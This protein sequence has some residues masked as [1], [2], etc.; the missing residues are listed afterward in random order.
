M[1]VKTANRSSL[2]SASSSY[3]FTTTPRSIVSNKPQRRKYREPSETGMKEPFNMMHD[4]RIRRGSTIVT[5]KQQQQ[6]QEEEE[7]QRKAEAL[8]KQRERLR[9]QQQL[10][11]RKPDTP[12]PIEGR[13][14][15]LFP[16]N[17]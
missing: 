7:A 14:H 3:T 4:P 2:Q 17:Q 6:A 9:L 16:C 1:S 11:Q 15:I 13:Q 12:E 10:E 8:R 5:Q